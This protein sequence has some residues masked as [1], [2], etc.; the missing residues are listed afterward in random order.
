MRASIELLWVVCEVF[1][2]RRAFDEPQCRSGFSCQPASEWICRLMCLIGAILVTSPLSLWQEAIL[3]A[4][5]HSVMLRRAS[6]TAICCRAL[7]SP[8]QCGTVL[9]LVVIAYRYRI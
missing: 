1:R 8:K 9:I 4:A 2:Q 5:E 3:S 7:Y 6:K